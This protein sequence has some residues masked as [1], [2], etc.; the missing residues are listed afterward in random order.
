MTPLGTH[1][2]PAPQNTCAERS[3]ECD[4]EIRTSTLAFRAGPAQPVIRWHPRGFRAYW[5]WKSRRVGGRLD[6]TPTK[7]PTDRLVSARNDSPRASMPTDGKNFGLVWSVGTGISGVY[8]TQHTQLTTSN[9]WL[10]WAPV[11]ALSPGQLF[12]PALHIRG[13]DEKR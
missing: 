13:R 6:L 11:S 8:R 4:A 5:R 12:G 7:Y 10:F 2:E 3:L 1:C 9:N